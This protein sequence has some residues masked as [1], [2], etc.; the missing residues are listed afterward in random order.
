MTGGMQFLRQW[1][2]CLFMHH[3]LV[4]LWNYEAMNGASMDWLLFDYLLWTMVQLQ[5]TI[6][7][8]CMY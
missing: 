2:N 6:M 8:V 7:A 5:R 1:W 4:Q 3:G